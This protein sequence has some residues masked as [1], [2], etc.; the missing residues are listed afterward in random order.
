M[1]VFSFNKAFQQQLHMTVNIQSTACVTCTLPVLAIIFP[2]HHRP[3]LLSRGTLAMFLTTERQT[4]TFFSIFFLPFC[5]ISGRCLSNQEFPLGEQRGRDKAEIRGKKIRIAPKPFSEQ[6]RA[7]PGC[8]PTQ[9][10]LS[11]SRVN[12]VWCPWALQPK[13]AFWWGYLTDG[14]LPESPVVWAFLLVEGYIY[15]TLL[16][17]WSHSNPVVKALNLPAFSSA[18]IWKGVK[19]FASYI[20]PFF[21]LKKCWI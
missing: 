15:C 20:L 16:H 11:P 12:T 7:S 9:A 1:L 14:L 21:F 19:D 17:L 6:D 5:H 10:G 8:C 3:S 13:I 18:G 2:G 4:S